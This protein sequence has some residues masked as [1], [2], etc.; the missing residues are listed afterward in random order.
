ME[1]DLHHL[2]A[3]VILPVFAFCNSGVTVIGVSMEHF[4]HPVP[5]GITLGL[6]IGKQIGVFGF[7]WLSI[8]TGF[9]RLPAG[10]SWMSLYGVAILC[11]IGFTM[12]LFIGSLAFEESGIN[13]IF[14]ERLGIVAGSILSGIVGYL[15]LRAGLANK[16][17]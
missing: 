17:D 6:F 3:L 5:V 12:S 14:D 1:R 9:A 7:C 10:V 2:V 11:G 15:I 8:K 16:R 13:K 4:F